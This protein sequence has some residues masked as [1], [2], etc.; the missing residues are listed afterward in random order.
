MSH[1][2]MDTN[3][4]FQKK[5]KSRPRDRFSF[6]RHQNADSDFF[7]HAQSAHYRFPAIQL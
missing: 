6:V 4:V 5:K 1:F 2:S 7:G 3:F